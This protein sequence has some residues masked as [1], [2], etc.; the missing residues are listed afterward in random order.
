MRGINW[1]AGFDQCASNCSI[2]VLVYVWS[3]M[4]CCKWLNL[5]LEFSFAVRH[6][7]PRYRKLWRHNDLIYT[8]IIIDAFV[9][10]FNC[11][12][13]DVTM[14][15]GSQAT[16]R[17]CNDYSG[18]K[19]LKMGSTGYSIVADWNYES[20]CWVHYWIGSAQCVLMEQ[21]KE[22]AEVGRII[23]LYR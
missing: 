16:G 1:P 6:A 13:H 10:K 4:S 23:L 17:T 2:Y 15:S 11:S 12:K 8:L 20:S 7:G 21:S 9:N 19:V 3:Q 18:S 22:N 5:S 14:V